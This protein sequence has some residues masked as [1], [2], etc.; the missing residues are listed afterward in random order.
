MF[1]KTKK[2]DNANLHMEKGENTMSA[3]DEDSL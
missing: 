2:L 3:A 1:Q